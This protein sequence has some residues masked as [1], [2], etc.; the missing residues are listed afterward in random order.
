[1]AGFYLKSVTFHLKKMYAYIRISFRVEQR[2]R[3]CPAKIK[4][5]ILNFNGRGSKQL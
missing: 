3:I 2:D 1:M 4:S 5:I